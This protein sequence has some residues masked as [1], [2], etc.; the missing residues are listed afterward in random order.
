M[1]NTEKY[2]ISQLCKLDSTKARYH[3][4]ESADEWKRT[5]LSDLSDVGEELICTQ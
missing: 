2:G 5:E 4:L 3:P 1:L